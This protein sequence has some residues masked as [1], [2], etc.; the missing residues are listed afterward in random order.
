MNELEKALDD[1]DGLNEAY[2]AL[3]D[4]D[5]SQVGKAELAKSLRQNLSSGADAYAATLMSSARAQP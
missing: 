5:R 4:V 2:R 3:W 1:L